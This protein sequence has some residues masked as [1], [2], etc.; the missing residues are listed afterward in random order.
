M[1]FVVPQ[2]FGDKIKEYQNA[3]KQTDALYHELYQFFRDE[4]SCVIIENFS[5][6][7]RPCGNKQCGGEYCDQWHGFGEDA[8]SG[9][10][11]FPIEGGGY[12]AIAYSS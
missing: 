3:K 12:A 8:I 2:E 1:A 4:M 11:Y 9:T 5:F 7:E 10:Y 6:T